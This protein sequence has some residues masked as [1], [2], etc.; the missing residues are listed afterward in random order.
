MN[1]A[2]VRRGKCHV[3][4]GTHRGEDSHVMTEA[5]IGETRS[6]KPRIDLHHQKPRR[7]KEG[8]YPESQRECDPSHTLILGFWPP[9]L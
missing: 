4:T 5:E 9:E 2:L 3:K 6:Y 1:G 7:G 8:L